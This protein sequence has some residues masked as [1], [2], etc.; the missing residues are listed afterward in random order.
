ME[1]PSVLARRLILAA[2]RMDGAY[3]Y[4]ARHSGVPE[5]Q[6]ALFYA[7][8]DGK[9]HSQ[10]EICED[11]LIPKTTINTVV[12]EQ[13]AAG[14]LTLRAGEGREKIICLTEA[15]RAY[16]EKAI[17]A[18]CAAECAAR[19]SSY[20]EAQARCCCRPLTRSDQRYQHHQYRKHGATEPPR[21]KCRG[22]PPFCGGYSS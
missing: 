13:V 16:A 4:F 3:Y 10:K 20:N 14:H 5:N 7:L 8:S 22:A 17:S 15:G 6:L 12:K 9:P 1:A 19:Y 2:T 11:W 18:L 21:F